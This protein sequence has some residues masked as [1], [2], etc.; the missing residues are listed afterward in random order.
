[1]VTSENAVPGVLKSIKPSHWGWLTLSAFPKEAVEW[2]D[3]NIGRLRMQGDRFNQFVKLCVDWC[4]QC[5]TKPNWKAMYEQRRL[6]GMPV[7]ASMLEDSPKGGE[8]PGGKSSATFPSL[9]TIIPLAE[10]EVLRNGRRCRVLSETESHQRQADFMVSPEG[11]TGV[12]NLA[13]LIGSKLAGE[14]FVRVLE[15]LKY[16]EVET[17]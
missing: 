17:P 9:R 8:A 2:A 15:N 10:N 13:K 5:G 6:Q 11:I 7:F 3:N 4:N 16:E 14:M 1:M 12:E